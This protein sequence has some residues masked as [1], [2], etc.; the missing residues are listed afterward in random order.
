MRA[1]RCP[2]C[3]VLLP[4]QVPS[5][6][7]RITCP[8]C[9]YQFIAQPTTT[10]PTPP[11]PPHP[12][13]TQQ[14]KAATFTLDDEHYLLD[15]DDSPPRRK[16]GL[17]AVVVGV[18]FLLAVGG[19]TAAWF[20][21]R[22]R[23]RQK[24]EVAQVDAKPEATNPAAPAEKAPEAPTEKADSAPKVLTG[25]QVNLRLLKSAV[26]ILSFDRRSIGCGSGA[27]VHKSRRLVVT[28]YHVVEQQPRVSVF[29][30]A[31]D[32][33]GE[34][35]TDPA[36]YVRN[37]ERLRVWGNVVARDPKVDLAILELERVP[38]NAFGLSLAARPAATGATVYSLGGSGV[39]LRDLSGALWRLSSGSVRGRY[40]DKAHF[41]S[42]QT[43]EAMFLE[44]QKP[45]NPGDSGGPT[46]NDRGELVGVVSASDPRKDLV[47]LDIDLTEVRAYLSAHAKAKGWAWDDGTAA[48]PVSID[49]PS[50]PGSPPTPVITPAG[51]VAQA[52]TGPAPARV[53]AIRQLGAMGD[54][55]RSAVPAL[56][57][58]LDDP[59]ERVRRMAAVALEQIGPPAKEDLGC[60]GKALAGKGK[61]GRLYALRYHASAEKV[62]RTQLPAL[63]TLLDEADPEIREATVRALGFFG[64][65]CKPVAFGKLLDRIN[66]P[67][68]AVAS[69]IVKV[70][71]SFTPFDGADRQVLVEN[72]S[73]KQWQLRALSVRLLAP[74]VPDETTALTWFEPRLVDDSAVVR[75]AAILELMRWGPAVKKAL[76]ALIERCR[77]DDGKVRTAAVRAIGEVG[78]GPGAIAAVVRHLDPE[79]LPGIRGIAGQVLIKL[80][81]VDPEAELPIL[82]PLLKSNDDMVKAAVLAML[83]QSGRPPKAILPDVQE[84][85]K[86]TDPVVQLEALR[87]LAVIGPDAA[88]LAPQ[89]I[90]LLT[91]KP[92][93]GSSPAVPPAEATPAGDLTGEQLANRLTKSATWIVTEQFGRPSSSGSGTLIDASRRLVLTNYH[94]VADGG[95]FTVFFP[96]REG[97]EVKTSPQFYIANFQKLQKAGYATTGRVVLANPGIDLAV[98]R[99]DSPVPSGIVPLPLAREGAKPGQNLHSIGASG[100]NLTRFD[101]ALWRYSAG[102]ART[103]YDFKLSLDGLQSVNCRVLETDMPINPGDSG[104]AVVNDRGELVGVNFAT[105]STRRAVS[106]AVDLGVVKPA[107]EKV[108]PGGVGGPAS[109][110]AATLENAPAAGAGNAIQLQAVAALGQ[111]GPK[112]AEPLAKALDGGL[113]KDVR[114][115]IC[116]ALGKQ[117]AECPAA[118][119]TYLFLAADADK[120]LRPAVADALGRIGGDEVS[121]GLRDR[122]AWSLKSTGRGKV[123][124]NKYTEEAELWAI[125]VLGKLD[126]KRLSERERT[127][128]DET[129]R[130][131]SFK[132]PDEACRTEAR[133]ALA[134]LVTAGLK[135]PVKKKE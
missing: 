98:I 96:F 6:N 48:P 103:V 125:Q 32:P 23:N 77:D 33:N 22:E 91:R 110:T 12:A 69:M 116:S 7:T 47:K 81:P 24:E 25:E 26:F 131:L 35:I 118:A 132:D 95:S 14:R 113:P 97:N 27:L 42:G 60:I 37:A 127:N 61:F 121:R 1:V 123:K 111:F 4:I 89:V 67:D 39:N 108:A 57:E 75:E 129:L 87:V 9:R 107:V 117:G 18:F 58:L 130:S 105:Q 54:A 20:V 51:L 114:E 68:P 90:E 16:T 124:Q 56:I 122:T 72:L 102:R 13:T 83:A 28:N 11:P 71:N 10:A 104:S 99:L 59:E 134:K 93:K 128:L 5:P 80:K 84:C 49:P 106:F 44:T 46:V 50:G 120:A 3:E 76:P 38:D 74:T 88:A 73:H 21:V 133:A 135:Q 63:V 17:V 43:V 86:S 92:A 41:G 119:I 2:S 40:K 19:A 64:P 8:Q 94:V 29:F 34:L 30:P 36:H 45:I 79:A 52:R 100:V 112:A 65:N 109:P 115:Q 70:L 101:G 66:D 78:G 53:E 55:A 31:F 62:D 15:D 126:P 85:L 82:A